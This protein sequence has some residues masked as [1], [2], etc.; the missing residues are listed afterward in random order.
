MDRSY[1]GGLVITGLLLVGGHF[2][3]WP[4]RLGRLQAYTYGI[5]AMYAGL[6]FWLGWGPEFCRLLAFALVAGL[7]TLAS[8]HYDRHRNLTIRARMADGRDE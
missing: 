1:I 8:Y 4:R 2:F 3:P 6:L 7:V 5:G